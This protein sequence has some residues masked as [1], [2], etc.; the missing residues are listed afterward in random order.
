MY[1]LKQLNLNTSHRDGNILKVTELWWLSIIIRLFTLI[2]KVEGSN[3]STS[4]SIFQIKKLIGKGEVCGL[5]LE[6]ACPDVVKICL[7]T[8][9]EVVSPAHAQPQFLEFN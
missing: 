3:P 7:C 4:I 5:G 8:Y 9:A 2:L 1:D 6:R